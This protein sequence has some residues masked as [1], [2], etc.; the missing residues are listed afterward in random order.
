[1]TRFDPVQFCANIERYK[2]NRALVVPPVLVVLARHP[3]K[4]TTVEPEFIVLTTMIAVDQYDLSS[5]Q[6]LL[7]GAAPLSAP[8]VQ[9][10]GSC[11]PNPIP[12]LK[13][14]GRWL[15]GLQVSARLKI[16]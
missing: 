7:S 14:D 1:M 11:H 6:T 2:V 8:L 3:G 10:V 16:L 15:P 12:R 4:S 5:L 9:Q 13:E